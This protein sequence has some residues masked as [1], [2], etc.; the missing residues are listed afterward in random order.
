M[1]LLFNGFVKA[2][3]IGCVLGRVVRFLVE[4]VWSGEAA[5]V[6]ALDI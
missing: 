4:A 3:P 6:A 5:E 2:P 1:L